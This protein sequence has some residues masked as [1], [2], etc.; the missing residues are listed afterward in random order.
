MVDALA[1]ISVTMQNAP[2][3]SHCFIEWKTGNESGTSNDASVDPST[4][5]VAFPAFTV[6]TQLVGLSPPR[7]L[8]LLAVS[9][10]F[11]DE[12]ASPPSTLLGTVQ[13]NVAE[14]LLIDVEN[15]WPLPTFQRV[16]LLSQNKLV[17]Q[18][19]GEDVRFVLEISLER[20]PEVNDPAAY[21][22]GLGQVAL[23]DP[24][25]SKYLETAKN[26]S[27]LDAPSN[28]ANSGK[29]E[30]SNTSNSPKQFS[31]ALFKRL[32]EQRALTSG[33][34]T[35]AGEKATGGENSN[36]V[37]DAQ[38]LVTSLNALGMDFGAGSDLVVSDLSDIELSLY[39][40]TQLCIYDHAD[41]FESLLR[42]TQFSVLA[43]LKQDGRIPSITYVY[44]QSL[45]CSIVAGEFQERLSQSP[46]FDLYESGFVP[47]SMR[48][49]YMDGEEI[50]SSA[51]IG[52]N[53]QQQ[54]QYQS[55]TGSNQQQ[56]QTI[57]ARSSVA[58]DEDNDEL[59]AII[60][61]TL[62]EEYETD[63]VKPRALTPDNRRTRDTLERE[64]LPIEKPV[65]VPQ[66]VAVQH[67]SNDASH[68]QQQPSATAI[69]QQ[70]QSTPSQVNS[71]TRKA[72]PNPMEFE[73]RTRADTVV[74]LRKQQEEEVELLL[75]LL[76]KDVG[77]IGGVDV[78]LFP[79]MAGRHRGRKVG[80]GTV[81]GFKSKEKFAHGE[82]HN[83]L[84]WES[85]G[86]FLSNP[87]NRGATPSSPY[88]T[89]SGNNTNSAP[90]IPV[91]AVTNPTMNNPASPPTS[92]PS[93]PLNSPRA[94]AKPASQQP[95]PK[96][97]HKSQPHPQ[98]S[99]LVA[100]QQQQRQEAK[101]QQLLNNTTSPT[102]TNPSATLAVPSQSSPTATNGSPSAPPINGAFLA[103][104]E[105]KP[106]PTI[107][108]KTNEFTVPIG[109][110]NIPPL[111]TSASPSQ[112]QAGTGG[113]LSNNVRS[114]PSSPR[115]LTPNVESPSAEPATTTNQASS[116]SH[117][118]F[119]TNSNP[120]LTN[121]GNPSYN[122]NNNNPTQ[123]QQVASPLQAHKKPVRKRSHSSPVG[124][125]PAV[126]AQPSAT[127]V[128]PLSNPRVVR[129]VLVR[130][131]TTQGPHSPMLNQPPN[132]NATNPNATNTNGPPQQSQQQVGNPNTAPPLHVPSSP[133]KL[134]QPT[135]AERD[136][137]DQ[138]SQPVNSNSGSPSN[139]PRT[140]LEEDE[141]RNSPNSPPKNQNRMNNFPKQPR[142]NGPLGHNPNANPN[143]PQHQSNS[144]PHH[145][146]QPM[147]GQPQLQREA[148]T[149]NPTQLQREPT[150]QGNALTQQQIQQAQ[151]TNPGQQQ[152]GFVEKT[153]ARPRIVDRG[154]SPKVSAEHNN[155]A[156]THNNTTNKLQDSGSYST[157]TNE[158]MSQQD[159]RTASNPQSITHVPQHPSHP[160][161]QSQSATPP[162]S[163]QPTHHNTIPSAHPNPNMRPVNQQQSGQQQQGS[164]QFVHR[165][166][167]AGSRP[168]P[169][170]EQRETHAIS[171]PPINLGS[172][173]R[174][175]DDGTASNSVADGKVASGGL[176]HQQQANNNISNSSNA[177]G[178]VVLVNK[179]VV[180]ASAN[181]HGE[182]PTSIPTR[183]RSKS[184]S[185]LQQ[186]QINYNQQQQQGQQQQQPQQMNQS[187][188]PPRQGQ[189]QNPNNAAL[190]G[191]QQGGRQ[192]VII[193]DRTQ[194]GNAPPLNLN[195]PAMQEVSSNALSQQQ[196]QPPLSPKQQH[197]TNPPLSPKSR[198]Q[199]QSATKESP[200]QP[201]QLS[202][203]PVSERPRRLV[204]FLKFVKTCLS[205]VAE[206]VALVNVSD[207]FGDNE[208]TLREIGMSL[209]RLQESKAGMKKLCEQDRVL[210]E[211]FTALIQPVD[212]IESHCLLF[213]KLCLVGQDSSLSE[214]EV[215]FESTRDKIKKAIA[216]FNGSF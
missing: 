122:S 109:S 9:A 101:E 161:Q 77:D 169:H 126:T 100:K 118:Q 57:S 46:R 95:R 17:P 8:S 114:M 30:R 189:P 4:R 37:V 36:T 151:L 152:S 86:Q 183:R 12:R 166:Q 60:E 105:R 80:M 131:C 5:A 21:E 55:A 70:P 115:N 73:R 132:P 78:Q 65:L 123:I 112:Q 193:R 134:Q 216:K 158:S 41:L 202:P 143:Q 35:R 90:E 93:S 38:S 171:R 121:G 82:Q 142:P 11:F 74:R 7:F 140:T 3:H 47:R 40:L 104:N 43:P 179:N 127:G 156:I 111:K 184:L 167:E 51:A 19:N 129:A 150:Q 178:G 10:W 13:F 204:I 48:D 50:E 96:L 31:S 155:S 198:E 157:G 92:T 54:S 154:T 190:Q 61:A 117:Q 147:T 120:T 110:L 44:Y 207:V 200:Q 188:D 139:R 206:N 33:G 209:K 28:L 66:Q 125:N 163:N 27:R 69:L 145:Q 62:Q 52:E 6:R 45:Y 14:N 102:S 87:N 133:R 71:N 76:D 159:G 146:Q 170:S 177:T 211:E 201:A 1:T 106:L 59:A 160:Q 116:P 196:Q 181:E 197:T 53:D 29:P 149:T 212:I 203:R 22:L 214:V 173:E 81:T 56:R 180:N 91:L 174:R 24:R 20:A 99:Q 135:T 172:K 162:N 175:T 34:T 137:A 16:S 49:S 2:Q 136:G 58:D 83:I 185:S 182:K 63:S 165:G 18:M 103:S 23:S 148:T 32:E 68:Q 97:L 213:L 119:G 88:N 84:E 124:D 75:D 94:G 153:R 141:F 176:P 144:P 130:H 187:S 26:I 113:V 199:Q 194:H 85:S 191:Q 89:N 138:S 192:R 186:F 164:P 128:P 42:Y 210:E 64:T 15:A 98:H 107:P 215:E 195:Q 79:E 39:I 108:R 25:L 72:L 208:Q 168:R 205:G 67:Q